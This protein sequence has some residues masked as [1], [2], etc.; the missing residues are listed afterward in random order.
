M[1]KLMV[2]GS[3]GIALTCALLGFVSHV[4]KGTVEYHR[5]E[6]LK[7]RAD[8][9]YRWWIRIVPGFVQDAFWRGIR[10][11]EEFHQEALISLRFLEQRE[12]VLSNQNVYAVQQIGSG[13]LAT[14]SSARK[15]KFLFVDV[16]T[17]STNVMVVVARPEDMLI[18]VDAIRHAELRESAK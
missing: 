8:N 7:A 11:R 2:I 10:K 5:S 15:S 1:R 18:M 13:F 17:P 9:G 6:Y 4:N 14:N 12:F 16:K 3:V